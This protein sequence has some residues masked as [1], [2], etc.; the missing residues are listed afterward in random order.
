MNATAEARD[1]SDDHNRPLVREPLLVRNTR[2]V[3]LKGLSPEERTVLCDT[4]YA[5]Y[6]AYKKGLDRA[7]FERTFFANDEGTVGLFC[8][9]DGTVRGFARLAITHVT[10]ESRTYAVFSGQVYV[11]TRYQGTRAVATHA[12]SEA[13]RFKLREPL[14]PLAYLG[15]S[16]PASYR[17]LARVMPVFYPS[18]H[19]PTPPSVAGLILACARARGL[20]IVDEARLLVKGISAP[21][22]PERARNA[23]SVAQDPDVRFYLETN[24]G[25]TDGTSLLV[26]VPMYLWNCIGGFMRHM[27]RV[28]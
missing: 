21:L 26:F 22:D 19:G 25:F 14:T 9:A 12:F 18:R 10:H 5:L 15:V 2:R 17:L 1:R 20:A 11:D 7:A 3:V 24:P 23:R 16:L 13:M 6:A 4:T 28:R 8:A 27:L